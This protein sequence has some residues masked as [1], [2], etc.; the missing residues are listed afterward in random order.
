MQTTVVTTIA[1][2]TKQSI[3]P[4]R[5]NGMAG[6]ATAQANENTKRN[7]DGAEEGSAHLSTSVESFEKVLPSEN[8]ISQQIKPIHHI[9]DQLM[10]NRTVESDYAKSRTKSPERQRRQSN[11]SFD[12]QNRRYTF[13]LFPFY[14]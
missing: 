5:R 8:K 4:E 3:P 7:H 12:D 14:V 11:R 9:S 2:D 10:P 6:S 13:H 1:S